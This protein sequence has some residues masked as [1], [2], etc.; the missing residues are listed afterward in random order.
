MAGW[1]GRGISG[2][3]GGQVVGWPSCRMASGW[4]ASGWMASGWVP[5]SK[6]AFIEQPTQEKIID[7]IF[8]EENDGKFLSTD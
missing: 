7:I 6:I 2:Q 3:G 4:M 8:S 1:N 5:V